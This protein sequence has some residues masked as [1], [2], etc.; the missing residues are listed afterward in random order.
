MF[1]PSHEIF[2][3]TNIYLYATYV[4]VCGSAQSSV[5]ECV[6]V[7]V[8]MCVTWSVCCNSIAPKSPLESAASSEFAH[9]AGKD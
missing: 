7:C 6:C 8:R 1:R 4:K 3:D 9:C 5:T 2:T